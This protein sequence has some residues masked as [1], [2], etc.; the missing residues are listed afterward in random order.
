MS[1]V[2]HQNNTLQCLNMN[3]PVMHSTQEE[4]TVH[5]AEM[6]KVNTGLREIHL[7]KHEIRDFG[8]QLLHESLKHN[9]SLT[10]LDISWYKNMQK[11]PFLIKFL[12]QPNQS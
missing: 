11:Y 2:L 5:I 3:R 1:T 9:V 4:S 7:Q 10:H 6:L 8:A 12:Q